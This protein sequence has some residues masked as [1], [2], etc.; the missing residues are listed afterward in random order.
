MK[1]PHLK[2][3]EMAFKPMLE[4]FVLIYLDDIIVKN[5][6]D[7]FGHLRQV[8]IK[9]RKFGVPL[10][11]SKCVFD[12]NRGKLLGHIILGDGLTIDPERVKEILALTLP[13]HKKGLQ[14]FLGRINFFRRFVPCLATMVKPLIAMLKKDMSFSWKKKRQG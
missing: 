11:L 14:S 2:L 10:N 4:K 8:F 7:Y 9:C 12:T 5:A 6:A 1:G 13:N 3:M